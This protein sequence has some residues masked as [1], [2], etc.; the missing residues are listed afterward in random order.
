NL[1]WPD[2]QE[3]LAEVA[4]DEP[5]DH[6]DRQADEQEPHGGEVPEQG[7]G[8]PDVV[9]HAL[10]ALVAAGTDRGPTRKREES[11]DRLLVGDLPAAA[12]QDDDAERPAPVRVAD[13]ARMQDDVFA[14][15]VHGST[16]LM[17]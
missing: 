6:E 12:D 8:E 3:V 11:E 17:S 5:V 13:D 2:R 4:G 15:D 14:V 7:T 16:L 10:G 9:V 1:A